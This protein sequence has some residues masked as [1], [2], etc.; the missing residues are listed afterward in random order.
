MNFNI[1]LVE[2]N[3]SFRQTLADTLLTH[4]STLNIEEVGNGEDALIKAEDLYPDMIFMDI[5]L[6]GENGLEATRKIKMRH[7]HTLIVI[8]TSHDIPEYRQQAFR[9]GADYFI[10]KADGSCLVDIIAW[11]EKAMADKN[12][13]TGQ[14]NPSASR[15][16]LLPQR[17]S[18]TKAC[19]P[20]AGL[21]LAA[22]LL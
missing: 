4:F 9:N 1:L 17:I 8:L 21:D 6:P 7:E 16:A 22:C 11:V 18:T 14:E 5:N 20:N 15:R 19:L 13:Q 10:S 12:T 3:S 2:D